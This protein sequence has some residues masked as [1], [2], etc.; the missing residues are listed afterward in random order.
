MHCYNSSS[1]NPN[2][3]VVLQTG[4]L[5]DMPWRDQARAIVESWYS[6]NVG[7]QIGR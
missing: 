7:E 5:V 1:I 6:G 3:V 4:N 2:T